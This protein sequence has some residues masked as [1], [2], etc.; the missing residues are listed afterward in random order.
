ML[1][2]M[3]TVFKHHSCRN[4]PQVVSRDDWNAGIRKTRSLSSVFVAF[5]SIPVLETRIFLPA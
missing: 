2:I 5:I 1:L 3:R 4:M